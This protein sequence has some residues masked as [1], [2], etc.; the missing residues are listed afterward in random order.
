MPV[1]RF[2]ILPDRDAPDAVKIA[3]VLYW[4]VLVATALSAAFEPV[5]RP[6]GID[7]GTWIALFSGTSVVTYWLD[8]YV[9]LRLAAGMRWA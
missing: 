8:I 3:V 7:L 2:S 6:E 1:H 9:V 4:I 5:V